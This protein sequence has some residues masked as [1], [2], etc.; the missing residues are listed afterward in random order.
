MEHLGCF[1]LLV[2]T[3]KASLNIVEHVLMWHDE[4]SFGYILKSGIAASSGT[5]IS[6]FRRN[7][8]IDFQ[9]GCTSLQSHQK[10]RRVHLFAHPHQ[11]VLTSEVLILSHSDWCKVESHGRF[12]LHLSDN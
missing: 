1:Q 8:Q 4:T 12:Y 10:W 5:S 11:H 7:L 6:Y 2:I 9:T 3:N